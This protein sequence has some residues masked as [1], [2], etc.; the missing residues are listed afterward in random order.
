M[1]CELIHRN[2]L[3]EPTQENH[4][5]FEVDKL[6]LLNSSEV[7]ARKVWMLRDSINTLPLRIQIC[8][9]KGICPRIL[10][11][12]L[13]PWI[14]V[15]TYPDIQSVVFIPKFTMKKQTDVGK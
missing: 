12:G 5:P 10:W 2:W 6:L 7:P 4:F 1:G 15:I 8:P 14:Q 9:K 3:P 11:M 13:R